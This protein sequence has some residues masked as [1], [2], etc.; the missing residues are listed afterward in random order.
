[1]FSLFSDPGGNSCQDLVLRNHG[2][3]D[4]SDLYEDPTSGD[5]SQALVLRDR[6]ENNDPY[7]REDFRD[8]F[9]GP[10]SQGRISLDP[11]NAMTNGVTTPYDNSIFDT[12]QS[13]T[14]DGNFSARYL[15]EAL[16]DTLCR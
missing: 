5:T 14:A 3:G 10:P 13:W 7:L 8:Y 15:L 6:S 9:S 1:M 11:E 12:E 4:Y 2:E 16:T